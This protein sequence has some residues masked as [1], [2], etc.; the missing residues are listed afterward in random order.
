LIVSLFATV[1]VMLLIS[2]R[3][4]RWF[5]LAFASI[6]VLFVWVAVPLAFGFGPLNCRGLGWYRYF[7]IG[8]VAPLSVALAAC[9]AR[10]F[11]FIPQ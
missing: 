7:E 1:A 9:V 2:P 3:I 8:T 6:I 4:A 5:A 10:P 11:A